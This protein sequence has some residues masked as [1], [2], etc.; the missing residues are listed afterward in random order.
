MDIIS[1]VDKIIFGPW[2]YNSEVKEYDQ[3]AAYY[4]E[5]AEMMKN[6]CY[7]RGIEFYDKRVPPWQ[8]LTEF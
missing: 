1:F 2:N 5:L 3:H 7:E 6:Y 8:Q 4:A